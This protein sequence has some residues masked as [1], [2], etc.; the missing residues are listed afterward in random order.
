[1]FDP[2]RVQNVCELMHR[3]IWKLDYIS[4]LIILYLLSPD[5]SFGKPCH[6]EG[7]IIMRSWRDKTCHER[8]ETDEAVDVF[9]ASMEGLG[10]EPVSAYPSCFPADKPRAGEQQDESKGV[11]FT[12]RF[13]QEIPDPPAGPQQATTEHELHPPVRGD[14]PAKPD[15]IRTEYPARPGSGDKPVDPPTQGWGS[16]LIPG[17]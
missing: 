9:I 4:N 2:Q 3:F 17:R 1:M 10:W 11:T 16:G 8:F 12:F 14:A 6:A 5:K 13:K 15:P 7:K